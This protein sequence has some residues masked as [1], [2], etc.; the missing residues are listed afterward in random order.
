M[1]PQFWHERWQLNEIGFHQAQTHSLL[2][3]YW[4]SLGVD[5]G[6]VFVPLCGK[7]LDMA[8]LRQQGH[9]VLGI[10]LSR[11]AVEDFFKEQGLEY[12]TRP[13]DGFQ[14]YESEG[15]QILCGDF[16]ALKPEH[17]SGIQAVYD[18]AALIALPADLQARYARHLLTLLPHRPPML[19]ITFEYQQEA[20]AGP[21]FSTPEK[22][23]REW[24]GD[25]Y[26]IETLAANEIIEEVPGLKSRGLDSLIEKAYRLLNLA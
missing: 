9:T 18:R 8:W 25:Q 14:S 4:P 10:E 21:P 2:A 12:S 20:M 26:A 24:F 15:I 22:P 6:R 3:R 17:L 19:L 16:F 11:L 5:A 1:E 23:V 7:S 13:L